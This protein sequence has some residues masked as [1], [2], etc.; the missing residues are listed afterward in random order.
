MANEI[1]TSVSLSASKGGASVA[2]GTK[3]KNFD[4]TGADMQQGTQLVGYAA[5]EEIVI[6]ADVGTEGVVMITNLDA[7]NPIELSYDTGAN[8]A[9]YKFAKVRAGQSILFQPAY[10]TSKTKIYGQATTA[11]VLAQVLVV[12]E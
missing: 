11:D 9:A 7:A 10:P 12:E 1:T 4:M 5:D 2:S 8:F 3:S 6:N